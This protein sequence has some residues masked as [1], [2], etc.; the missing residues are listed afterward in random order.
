MAQTKCPRCWKRVPEA[1]RF[2]RRC[3]YAL[4]PTAPQGGRSQPN[5]AARSSG[6]P[7]GLIWLLFILAMMGALFFWGMFTVGAVCPTPINVRLTSPAVEMP[8]PTPPPVVEIDPSYRD[9]TD[10]SATEITPQP[11][12]RPMPPRVWPS[13]PNDPRPHLYKFRNPR[14]SPAPEAPPAE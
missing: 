13:Y 14:K 5:H 6:L 3:G 7:L 11:S 8:A 9:Q 10:G 2:C 12:R 1:A 4:Q